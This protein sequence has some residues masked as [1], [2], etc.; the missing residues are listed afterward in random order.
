MKL[1][2]I[3]MI[4][5]ALFLMNVSLNYAY[6]ENNHISLLTV[7][8]TANNTERGGIADLYLTIKPGSG[9]IFIDSFPLTKIDTQITT[10]FANELACDF[11]NYDCSKHDFFYTIKANSAIV[12]GP[13]AGAATTV[14]TISSLDETELDEKTI[15]TGTINSGNLIGPVAGVS[16]KARAAQNNEF[17][18]VLVPKWDIENQTITENLSISIVKVSTLEEALFEFT[19]KDYSQKYDAVVSSENYNNFM[20]EIAM[21][22][23]SKYGSFENNILVLPNL[24]LIL[25]TDDSYYNA[26]DKYDDKLSDQG[27]SLNNSNTT[28][29]KTNYFELA[30]DAINNEEYYSAASF[31]FAGNYRITRHNMKSF[32]LSEL[33]KE[34]VDLFIQIDDFEKQTDKKSNSLNTI[35]ELETY[36]V[37]KERIYDA[38]KLLKESIKEITLNSSENNLSTQSLNI[39]L[40]NISYE[41]LAYAKE[42][43]NTAI[44]WSK[45]FELPGENFVLDKKALESA[46]SKK[47]SEAEERINYLEMYLPKETDREELAYAYDYFNNENY[48]MCIFTASKAKA[49]ANVVLSAIFVDK[50]NIGHLLNEKLIA[51]EKVIAKEE[52]KNIFPIL[53]YSYYEYS[54][55]LQKTDEF[56]SLLY[57]EYSLELSNLDMYFPKEKEFS[58]SSINFHN[59]NWGYFWLFLLGFSFGMLFIIVIG[60]IVGKNS[61]K[62]IVLRKN[63]TRK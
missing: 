49:E 43:F 8:E 55:T 42:R 7:A 34:Y 28:E 44:I 41:S 35:S 52:S 48:I 2:K 45:F 30:L 53:G 29:E 18:K 61:K 13:S 15:M 22:L 10:R 14:L 54:K 60:F 33:K 31:C 16:A 3:L 21:Q 63:K 58:L 12:G 20:K 11:L 27:I 38:K 40:E 17:E 36:M 1:I 9:R 62:K 59:F 6:I 32:T 4:F 46:C 57:A 23:C 19:G 5:F 26:S 50:Q 39:P 37:V 47:L 25:G 51:A 24:S 56:S